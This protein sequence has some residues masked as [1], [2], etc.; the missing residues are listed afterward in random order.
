MISIAA[1]LLRLKGIGV[2]VDLL[3]RKKK[4]C[5]RMRFLKLKYV[6]EERLYSDVKYERSERGESYTYAICIILLCQRDGGDVLTE[7]GH[8]QKRMQST[9]CAAKN[10][11]SILV[12]V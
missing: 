4:I 3:A 11:F 2:D 7:I 5:I 6:E 10:T 12:A 1:I 8:H 9:K